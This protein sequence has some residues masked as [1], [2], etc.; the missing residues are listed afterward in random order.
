MNEGW[1]EDGKDDDLDNNVGD[2]AKGRRGQRVLRHLGNHN[3]DDDEI[4]YDYQRL[5]QRR[6]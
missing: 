1:R 3:D 5:W 2:N 4:E 6:S